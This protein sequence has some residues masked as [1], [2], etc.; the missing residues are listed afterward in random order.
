MAHRLRYHPF[1]HGELGAFQ[2]PRRSAQRGKIKVGTGLATLPVYSGGQWRRSTPPVNS[3][4]HHDCLLEVFVNTH[5]DTRFCL[6]QVRF[7]QGKLV[8]EG[9]GGGVQIPQIPTGGV[10]DQHHHQW[11]PP[12]PPL[13]HYYKLGDRWLFF[14]FFVLRV[15][16]GVCVRVCL[17]K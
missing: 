9:G 2:G 15:W 8:G 1:S 17:P 11:C 3:T 10:D 5:Y 6:P 7:Q 4:G 12:P 14:F 13:N 16:V